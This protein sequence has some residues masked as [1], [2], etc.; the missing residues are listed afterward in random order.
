MNKH[1][2]YLSPVAEFK[3]ES[4]VKYLNSEWGEKSKRKFLKELKQSISKIE[5]FPESCPKSESFSGIYKCVVS[6]LTSFYYRIHANEIE[7]LTIT[8]N[9]QNP[10]DLLE[11]IRKFH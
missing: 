3:L 11:E 6:K 2:V 8:D 4:L 5:S 1:K 9:R 10:N 7:I